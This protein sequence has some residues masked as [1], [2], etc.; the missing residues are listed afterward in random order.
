MTSAWKAGKRTD[1]VLQTVSLAVL[2]APLFWMAMVLF[3]IFSF[4]LG[5]FPFGGAY[6]PGG[7]DGGWLAKVG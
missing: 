2:S 6:T 3:Y 1:S 7:V 5:W 4:K